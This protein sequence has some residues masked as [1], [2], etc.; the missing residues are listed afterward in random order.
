M[1]EVKRRRVSVGALPESCALS[2]LKS[3]GSRCLHLRTSRLTTVLSP[4]PT[5][6]RLHASTSASYCRQPLATGRR[7]VSELRLVAE[8]RK[9]STGSGAAAGSAWCPASQV[10]PLTLLT[11]SAQVLNLCPSRSYWTLIWILE[12][13]VAQV[14]LPCY[15]HTGGERVTL[16]LPAKSP[17]AVSVCSRSRSLPRA[18]GGSRGGAGAGAG[19]AG[20]GGGSGG[21]ASLLGQTVVG[22]G[23]SAGGS[24]GSGGGGAGHAGF[25]DGPSSLPNVSSSDM[26]SE[27]GMIDDTRNGYEGRWRWGWGGRAGV[28]VC[29]PHKMCC[30]RRLLL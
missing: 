1:S 30:F 15:P 22:G 13:T 17:A 24:A 3:S 19:E 7:S 5:H 9:L 27:S 6:A 21:V 10:L 8:R 2:M 23:A 20:G 12:V 28:V 26:S 29:A 11:V 16:A 18:L 25:G 14:E 4:A